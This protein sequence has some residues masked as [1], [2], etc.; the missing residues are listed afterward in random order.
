MPVPGR[1][2]L[3]SE[4]LDQELARHPETELEDPSVI[5]LHRE[6]LPVSEQPSDARSLQ[7]LTRNPSTTLPS[8]DH[9]STLDPRTVNRQAQ[10]PSLEGPANVLDF[11]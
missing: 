8:L 2:R 10:N 7:E 6:P 3:R 9:V 4:L 1:G 11:R 5:R